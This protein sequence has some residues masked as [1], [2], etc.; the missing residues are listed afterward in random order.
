MKKFS[1]FL[2]ILLNAFASELQDAIDNAQNGDIIELSNGVYKGGIL[3]NKAITIN[4]VD[5][6]AIIDANGVGSVITI[7]S[8]NVIIKNLTIQNSGSSH[9]NLDAGINAINANHIVIENNI[10]KDVLFGIDLKQTQEAVVVKNTISSRPAA[11]GLRGDALRL[12][13]SHSGVI[14]QNRVTNARDIV[15]WYSSNN[16]ISK[17][18]STNCRYSLHFMY[19]GANLVED[20]IFENNSVGIFFMFSKGSTVRNNTVKNSIGAFG[21]GIGMKDTSDFKFYNNTLMYNARGFYLDQSPFQ[22][23]TTN[24][25]DSNIVAYNTV[26][27]QFHATQHKS[28]FTNNTFKGNMEV[29]NNDT[30]GSKL[31]LNQWSQNYFDD[32]EGMDRDKDGFGDIAYKNYVY[33]DKL[34]QQNKAVQFFYG[35]SVMGLLNFLAKLAPFSEPSLLL[36][37]DMPR[38]REIK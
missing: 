37:D 2:L 28:I 30:L 15:L 29:A 35:S 3:I 5:N 20:N 31:E 38:M 22:P 17:N 19:A 18:Y 21:V 4:G 23:D 12:W 8:P 25:F 24:L 34:W 36:S 33:A 32:Y 13:Y 7:T 6:K 27:I 1:L 26:G 9:E 11:L 16:T 10:I 14:K